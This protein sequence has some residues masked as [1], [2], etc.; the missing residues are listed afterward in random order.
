MKRL[1][2]KIY[3]GIALLTLFLTGGCNKILNET[4]RGSFT[5]QYFQSANGV[6]GG[7]TSL[8]ASLR[9]LWGNLYYWDACQVGTDETTWG[10]SGAGGAS[11]Q[12]FDFS[13]QGLVPIP[14]SDYEVGLLWGNAFPY[15]NTASGVIENGVKAGVSAS[16][17]A[18]ARFFRAFYYFQMV[19]TYGGVPLDL[20]AGRLKFNT[21]AVQ[22][23]VR[24]SVS[25]VYTK[26]VFP[27]LLQ[28]I[29]DLSSTQRTTGAVTKQVA[30]LFLAK[31]YLTYGWWLENPNN[32]PSYPVE[33]GGN[34]TPRTDPDGHNPAWY[35]QQAYN[36]AVSAIQTP[37]SYGLQ[38]T[39]YDVNVGSNDRN[40]ECM[41]YADHTQLN[42]QYAVSSLTYGSGGSPDN[43][44]CWC[45]TWNYTS[46]TSSK[47][48]GSWTSVNSVQ[49]ASTQWG[50]RPWVR[51]APPIEVFTKTFADKTNDS[52]YDGTFVSV[53]RCN[54]NEA[55][56]TAQLYNANYLPIYEGSAV[57]T[58]L[59]ADSAG[60][61]YSNSVYKS[62]VGAGVL[63]GRADFV[64][65]PSAYNR[66]V[67]PGIWKIN[68]YRTD[69]GTGLG[70]PNAGSTRPYV[71]AKFS[72]LFFIAAEAAVKGA[73]TSPV[74]GTYANDGTA[75][76]L[77]N[78]IRA[79]AGKW[80]FSNANN[81]TYVAD[82]SA[83]MVAAT[84]ATITIGY[85][86]AERSREFYGE[87]YRVF[88]LKRVQRWG[89]DNQEGYNYST[90]TIG[91][92]AYTS[93]TPTT[94]SRYITAPY[95]LFPIPQGQIDLMQVSA[96]VKKAYQNPAYQ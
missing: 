88:D 78:V 3:I 31:A 71:I 7:I 23:S 56:I 37:G 11:F 28:A 21:N 38:S 92:T 58:F 8:Y 60:V 45:Q 27:D 10:A 51:T 64:I 24:D 40:N 42:A 18:E 69:N 17:I 46:I 52:R 96:A 66:I 73:T 65:S 12:K 29:T 77:I 70:N 79:R 32:I 91:G 59:G 43:F 75:R 76:G 26:G 87:G 86:L 49:R 41:L 19:Q 63:P 50:G 4:P 9:N 55:G 33:A 34:G 61:D 94:Y 67:Y 44:A 53:Y 13:I 83:A 5:P 57:L 85:I 89:L 2:I 68:E 16:Y 1:H 30:Q 14:S 48:S 39:Y 95:Y 93:H 82:N 35:Y 47:S 80:K 15:I 74:T 36:I 72:E 62:S 54:Q 20:G 6:L 81:A 25:I 84:P 90:Y 22:N